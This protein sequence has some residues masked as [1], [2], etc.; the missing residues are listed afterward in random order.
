MRSSD[1]GATLYEQLFA[2]LDR[3]TPENTIV[4]HLGYLNEIIPNQLLRR[5]VF[6]TQHIPELNWL[7]TH[8]PGFGL[9]IS[10]DHVEIQLEPKHAMAFK[11]RFNGTLTNTLA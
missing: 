10:G 4:F 1:P 5:R 6:F 9:T 2:K 7:L 3:Y 11:L 8:A